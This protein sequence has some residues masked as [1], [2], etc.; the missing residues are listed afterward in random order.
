MDLRGSRSRLD[1]ATIKRLAK[2]FMT[3]MFLLSALAAR[4]AEGPAA[5][6]ATSVSHDARLSEKLDGVLRSLDASGAVFGARVVE[7]SSR[8]EL[9]AHE[10]DR[11]LM[12]ASNGKLPNDAAGLDHFG[13]K[14]AFKTYLAID[15]EDLWLV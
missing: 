3:L 1:A 11:P 7:L 13:P 15:G 2:Q 9:Y 8:R 6:A 10:P 4:G 12:P 5:L 14:H